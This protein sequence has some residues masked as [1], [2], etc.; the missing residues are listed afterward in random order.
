MSYDV[1]K[2]G[3]ILRNRATN[4]NHGEGW[5]S[6]E[7][8]NQIDA[9]YLKS[10][11][12][13]YHH[14]SK[15]YPRAFKAAFRRLIGKSRFDR[16]PSLKGA[17]AY[18]MV[19]ALRD[20]ALPDATLNNGTVITHWIEDAWYIESVGPTIG[21]KIADFLENDPDNPYAIAIAAEMNRIWVLSERANPVDEEK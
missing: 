10:T 9:I 4:H 18:F 16:G 1:K 2:T 3:E 14:W 20:K 8:P 17:V 11:R 21:E 19:Y 7:D 15:R 13:G 6:D 12:L 5:V